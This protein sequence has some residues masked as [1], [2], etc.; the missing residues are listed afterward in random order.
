FTSGY[1]DPHIYV[2][3]G[4]TREFKYVLGE[5]DLQG[6]IL[7]GVLLLLVLVALIEVSILAKDRKA[8]RE[9]ARTAEKAARAQGPGGPAEGAGAGLG[10]VPGWKVD[11]GEEGDEDK[12]GGD[13]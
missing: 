13:G 4:E 2:I 12:V 1:S 3:D 9:V 10:G 8:A 7:T 6:A 11:L 5:R